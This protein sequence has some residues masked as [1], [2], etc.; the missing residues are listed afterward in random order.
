[1][2]TVC[3]FHVLAEDQIDENYEGNLHRLVRRKIE[4]EIL[5]LQRPER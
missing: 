4:Q 2:K 5:G 1:M 3:W